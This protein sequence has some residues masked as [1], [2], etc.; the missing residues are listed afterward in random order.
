VTDLGY[1]AR[2]ILFAA[3]TEYVAT[4]EPVGSRT[5]SRRYGLNLS[6]ATIRNVLA[7]LEDAG[8]LSQ[9]HTS[10]GRVPTDKGFRVF[11]DALLQTREVSAEDRAAI[12][13]RMRAIRPGI[14]DVMRETGKMLASLTGAAAVVVTPRL[15]EERLSQLR[16]MPLRE[17]E[18][19]AVLISR[20]GAVQNRVVR[21][22]RDLDS[23]ELERV[24]NYLA[25]LMRG[26]RTLTELREKVAEEVAVESGSADRLRAHARRLLEATSTP[27]RELGASEALI[28]E[29]QGQLLDRPEFAD[30]DKLRALLRA[31]EDKQRLLELLDRTI[32]AGG[33]QVLIGKES[34]IGDTG[35]LSV[36][37][38][39]YGQGGAPTGTLG[40]IGPTRMDYGKVVPL[41]S[42][43]AR[44]VSDLLAGDSP[45]DEPPPRAVGAERDGK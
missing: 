17:G 39:A 35:D 40:V 4:G 45:S 41:V 24:H 32:G 8:F 9:P 38:A 37:S 15:E 29:G 19:L 2:R 14:D 21:I 25:E 12:E 23:A 22:G 7:D 27:A 5:L 31:F 42:F 44:V 43:T 26:G 3:I 34:N 6:P 18:L 33:I 28:V 1:R 11:V 30:V 16:F 13:R 36:V 10:A 20:S